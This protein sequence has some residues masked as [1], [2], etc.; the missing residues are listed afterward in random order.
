MPTTILKAKSLVDTNASE[1]L[2]QE[3]FDVIFK[4]IER[5]IRMLSSYRGMDWTVYTENRN[6]KRKENEEI[7]LKN[8]D[9][10]LLDEIEEGDEK[11]EED[12]DGE[13]K[14]AD[15]EGKA[16]EKPP[17]EANEAEE[18]KKAEDKP[19]EGQEEKKE[20]EGAEAD[21]D[22]DSKK[23]ED[24]EG[25]GEDGEKKEEEDKATTQRNFVQEK[26]KAREEEGL[27]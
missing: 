18:E 2:L 23:G 10:V 19:E 22:K 26:H 5:Y 24:G 11:K 4:E 25:E 16:A 12:K 1:I 7:T 15:K 9:N 20:G 17:S 14:P 3:A 13:D 21:K 27:K 8:D 6:Q